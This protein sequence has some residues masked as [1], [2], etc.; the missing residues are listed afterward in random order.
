MKLYPIRDPMDCAH[1]APLSMGFSKQEYWTGLPFPPPEDL[2]NPRI[3]PGSSEL[4][5]D[6]L[7]IEPPG[8]LVQG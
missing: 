4:Q 5:V 7:L 8:N 6:S 2:P 1:Q 3:K